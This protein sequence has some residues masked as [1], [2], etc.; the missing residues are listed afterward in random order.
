MNIFL[1]VSNYTATV[2]AAARH[3]PGVRDVQGIARQILRS[4]VG[5][6]GPL[7]VGFG[8]RHRHS[9]RSRNLPV[10]R[11]QR[12]EGQRCRAG[13]GRRLR[14]AYGISISPRRG[15]AKGIGFG[16]ARRLWKLRNTSTVAPRKTP[17]SSPR[18]A[19]LRYGYFGPR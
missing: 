17:S 15:R 2:R 4:G 19:A 8:I 10:A 5:A 16:V 18:G 6:A 12:R 3:R 7:F 14:W 9:A 13:V 11:D 1:F